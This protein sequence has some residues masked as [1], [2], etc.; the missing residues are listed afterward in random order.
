M[1]LFAGALY[2]IQ[3]IIVKQ[4]VE[5]G[6]PI[7][8]CLLSRSIFQVISMPIYGRLKGVRFYIEKEYRWKVFW[9]S[10]FYSIASSCVFT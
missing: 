6:I 2:G 8:E 10:L 1:A 7:T 4:A 9:I 5:Y 3:S